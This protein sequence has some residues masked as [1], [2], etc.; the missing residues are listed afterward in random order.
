[1]LGLCAT[2]KIVN[3]EE[4]VV[5]IDNYPPW[6]IIDKKTYQGIDVDIIKALAAELSLTVKFITCP[7]KRCLAFIEN[8]QADLM[9]GLFKTSE[10]EKYMMFIEPAYFDDPPKVFYLKKDTLKQINKYEDLETLIIG[11]KRGASYFDKFD[12][13]HK[14]KKLIVTREVQLLNLLK[15]GRIDTFVSTESFADYL[16]AKEGFNG[17]FTKASFHYGP[18]N[19][20]YLVISKKSAFTEKIALFQQSVKE[21]VNNGT[22]NKIA[23]DFYKRTA[24]EHK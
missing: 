8:G 3:A 1:M 4:L 6:S 15:I 5:A 10:R 19:V 21:A 9:P 7:F 24:I 14:L 23:D 12:N 17:E 16:I 13:D 22:Y 11:V 20:S 18:G 2:F